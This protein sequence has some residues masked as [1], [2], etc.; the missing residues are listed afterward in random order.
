M[1]LFIASPLTE[2]IEKILAEVIFDLKQK[3]GRVK[4]VDA[5]NI[6][7]TLKFLGETDE[8]NVE[9]IKSAIQQVAVRHHKIDSSINKIGAFPNL[10]RPRVIWVG[11]SEGIDALKALASDTENEMA[12]LGFE[13]EKRPFKTHLTLGRVKDDAGL[14]DLK[15]AIKNY[16][17]EPQAVIF[18]K[19]ILFKST[20]TPSGPIYDRLFEADLMG[21]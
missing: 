4:W 21:K 16:E 14:Y 6:H 19:I 13:K 2:E 18:D 8:S 10:N 12:E 11:L 9:P 15:E 7:L 20:L 5:K 3:R 1:R 17:L